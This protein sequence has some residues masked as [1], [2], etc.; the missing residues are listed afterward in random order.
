MSNKEYTCIQYDKIIQLTWHLNVC[1]QDSLFIKESIYVNAAQGGVSVIKI[2][3]L[4]YL[5]TP[6]NYELFSYFYQRFV[7]KASISWNKKMAPY[8][9]N[10]YLKLR[11]K[12]GQKLSC[13]NAFG[14]SSF[15]M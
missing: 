11:E 6:L 2:Y 4:I 14:F 8:N 7:E 1:P 12:K 9:K 5:Y 13:G 3:I 10:F 15:F